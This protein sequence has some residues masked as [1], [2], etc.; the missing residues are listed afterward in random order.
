[1]RFTEKQS[2]N[3]HKKEKTWEILAVSKITP[4]YKSMW[5][6]INVIKLH[7]ICQWNSYRK[8]KNQGSTL[9]G[10]LLLL[11]SPS[12]L[13]VSVLNSNQESVIGRDLAAVRY[14]RLC[15]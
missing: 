13:R 14:R 1:M 11:R 4:T 15:P 8:K 9:C 6:V 5:Q 12:E 2:P 10:Q 3:L 7:F